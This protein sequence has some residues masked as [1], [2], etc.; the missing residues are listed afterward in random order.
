MFFFGFGLR[1]QT[2]LPPPPPQ[3]GTGYP[4]TERLGWD[5]SSADKRQE[6]PPGSPVCWGGVSW[7]QDKQQINCQPL[8]SPRCPSYG[9]VLPRLVLAPWVGGREKFFRETSLSIW[10]PRV[11]S[12]GEE[13]CNWSVPPP[14][15]PRHIIQCEACCHYTDR[16][17]NNIFLIYKEIQM[18]SDAKSYMRKGFLIY[19]KMQKNFTIYE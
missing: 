16:K 9:T 8:I 11:Y 10:V 13:G 3:R 6:S 18:G 17:E 1:T 14:K 4:R 2:P 7:V 5:K 12:A 19:E 15:M